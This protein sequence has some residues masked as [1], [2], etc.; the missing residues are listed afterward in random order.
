MK[1]F[2]LILLSILG[3]FTFASCDEGEMGPTASSNPSSPEI[4]AP[5]SG[6]SYL[7]TEEQATDTLMTLE[8]KSPDYGFPSAPDFIIQMDSAGNS[9]SEPMEL[10]SVQD[11]TYS[12]TVAD[13][14]GILL[15]A[16]YHGGEEVSMELRVQASL[17]D[18]MNSQI[19]EPISIAFTPYSTCNYCP[20]IYAPGGYQSASGYISNWS[21]ADAP[22]LNTVDGKDT[23]EG[24]IYIANANSPYKLINER[25]WNNGDW[26]DSGTDSELESPGSDI[27]AEEAGYYKIN[28]DLNNMTYSMTNTEWAVTGDATPNG[29]ADDST[30]DHDMT[31]NSANKVWTIDLELGQGLL[32]FRAND[33]WNIEYGDTGADGQLVQ[34]GDDVSIPEVGNYTITLDLSKSPYT[35]TLEQN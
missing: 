21:L 32:K 6:G 7:L 4:T 2:N 35:Y 29:W 27:I 22:A 26:G 12:L 17:S 11:N 15:G 16:D 3:V 9:F 28:V 19:S 33:A 1:K 25:N 13:M 30:E 31:Y 8:W 24:Y 14:N 5:E 23:Y 34:G 10:G 18:S 20:A